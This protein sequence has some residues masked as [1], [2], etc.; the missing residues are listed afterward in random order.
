MIIR[1]FWDLFTCTSYSSH[2]VDQFDSNTPFTGG[3]LFTWV[4]NVGAVTTIPGIR[5]QNVANTNGYWIRQGYEEGLKAEWFGVNRTTATLAA[6]PTPILQATADTRYGAGVVVVSTDTYD[7]AALRSMFLAAASLSISKVNTQGVYQ[8]NRN[9]EI[10]KTIN[11]L[12]WNGGGAEI[13]ATVATA[14]SMISVETPTNEADAQIR[15]DNIYSISNLMLTGNGAI[16]QTGLDMGPSFG[17]RYTGIHYKN[18]ILGHISKFNLAARFENIR[19][20]DCTVGVRLTSG[21]DDLNAVLHWTAGTTGGSQ[22]NAVTFNNVR[23]Y[24][25]TTGLVVI[26]VINAN[27]ITVRDVIIEGS[28]WEKGIELYSVLSTVKQLKVSDMHYECVTGTT[29]AGT[30]QAVVYVR[31]LGGQIL[32]DNFFGQYGAVLLDTDQS[33]GGAWVSIKITNLPFWVLQGATDGFWNGGNAQ[34]EFS[35]C[36]GP[37]ITEA[38]AIATIKGTPP[39]LWNAPGDGTNRYIFTPIPV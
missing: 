15:V 30:D 4:E 21:N 24:H 36:G 26:Q 13:R 5:I 39:L 38:T 22:C 37:F 16:S 6:S 32:L 12:D 31:I 28:R 14:F 20:T 18:L 25:N 1:N 29:A 34:W 11:R 27:G 19:I 3:G 9:V 17:S 7:R 33:S 23:A 8:I 35:N 10:P 2:Y